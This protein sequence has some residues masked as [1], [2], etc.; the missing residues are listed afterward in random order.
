MFLIRLSVH[1]K[2]SNNTRND[3]LSPDVFVRDLCNGDL[4]WNPFHKYHTESWTV[5]YEP[6]CAAVDD[7]F[8]YTSFHTQ[9]RRIYAE[10]Q[11]F[12]NF[13]SALSAL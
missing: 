4:R 11:M 1:K 6:A 7:H 8:V 9:Y 3:T 5:W 13:L 10:I 2:V 12:L